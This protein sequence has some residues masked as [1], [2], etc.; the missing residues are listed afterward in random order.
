MF[1]F[2]QAFVSSTDIDECKE[3]NLTGRCVGGTC[4]NIFDGWNCTCPSNTTWAKVESIK[5]YPYSYRCQ[6]LFLSFR[7]PDKIT[8][9]NFKTQNIKN[10]GSKTILWVLIRIVCL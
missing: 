6:G 4:F 5:D 7:A 1:E 8:Y 9:C 2:K 10:C 3:G